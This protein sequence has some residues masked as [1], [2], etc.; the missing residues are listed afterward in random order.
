MQVRVSNPQFNRPGVWAFDQPEYFD[1]EGEEV[2]LKW[3]T[4]NQLALS[5][6]NPEWPVRV[7]ARNQIVSIDN[8]AFTQQVS[9]ANTKVV[10]GSKGEDYVVTLGP[11]MS[12]TCPG[13]QFR[14]T[15]KHVS[16]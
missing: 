13:F 8:V 14:K 16:S 2:K 12:C 9:A 5:T 3:T 4:P 6:G 15:C 10:K 1:Y 7:I 11:T